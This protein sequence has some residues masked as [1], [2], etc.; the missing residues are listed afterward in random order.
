MLQA[1]SDQLIGKQPGRMTGT[2]LSMLGLA[3]DGIVDL[4][5][6]DGTIRVLQFSMNRA[7][8][9]NFELRTPHS[10]GVTTAIKSRELTVAGNV[11]FHTNRFSGKFGGL[12][13]LELTPD[14]PELLLA[15]VELLEQLPDFVPVD[16]TDVDISLVHVSCDSM[17]A[18]NL[19]I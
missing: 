5:T 13:P 6:A 2:R 16:F 9:T 17:I 3:F 12:I 15:L 18:K 19:R 4:P 14:S 8:T 1:D 11:T 10:H 7:T